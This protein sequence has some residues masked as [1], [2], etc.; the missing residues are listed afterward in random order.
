VLFV[1]CQNFT[2]A[3]KYKFNGKELQDELGLNMYDYGARNYMAD[4]GRTSTIDPLAE[5]FYSFSPQSFLNNN[6]LTFVDPTG[7]AADGWITQEIDGEK[8]H[9]YNSTVNTVEEAK[10]AGY[11]GV[12][13]VNA[14]LKVSMEGEYSYNLNADGTVS[15]GE[16][17][18]LV[19]N[20]GVSFTTGAGT[21]ISSWGLMGP[22]DSRKPM[23]SGAATPMFFTSPAFSW[24]WAAKG[25]SSLW[26]SAFGS[27][28]STTGRVFWSG[29]EVAK[30]GAADFAAAN[31]M[32]T[33]EMTPKGGI[34][35]TV[36]PFLPRSVSNPIW[37]NL[38]TNFAKG[39]T[40]EVNFFT[41]AAG[42]R[43]SSIWLTVEQPI[44]QSNGVNVITNI[45]K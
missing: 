10:A 5:K 43:P 20:S 24:G 15:D 37:N 12:T 23:A 18:G 44:L 40:G 19:V 21:K 45:I 11:E 3:Y 42:P 28:T 39:A 33:L 4:L 16:G 8:S 7:M 27:S 32:K 22:F 30:S 34:M 31:G 6:P 29:G 38:S 1:V 17:N 25:L 41:T 13:D 14:A 9:T 2:K 26:G 35:N 36:S